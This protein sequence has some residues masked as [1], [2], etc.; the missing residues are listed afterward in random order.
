M[1]QKSD[2]T[3]RESRAGDRVGSQRLFPG[4]HEYRSER[5]GSAAKPFPAPGAKGEANSNSTS[6]CE[7]ACH[8]DG[9]PRVG[10][11]AVEQFSS[12][13]PSVAPKTWQRDG[14]KW[15]A[16]LEPRS[17]LLLPLQRDGQLAGDTGVIP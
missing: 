5:L 17:D 15:T 13:G 4:L 16:R 11:A 6:A 3:L 8:R 1:R 12:H 9:K 2:C 7:M 14:S 10:I